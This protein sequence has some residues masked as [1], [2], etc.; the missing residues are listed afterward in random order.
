MGKRWS[1][2]ANYYLGGRGRHFH[3]ARA[4]IGRLLED[5][6]ALG[7]DHALCTG[8]ITQMSTP[9]EFVEAGAALQP[10]LSQRK[11]TIIPGNHDRY[12]PEAEQ[13]RWFEETFADS[14]PQNYPEIRLLAENVS[15]ILIDGS[16]ATGLIDSSGWCGK[17][18]LEQLSSMVTDSSLDGHFVVLAMHY[19]LRRMQG[20]PDRKRH[21]LRDDREL[22]SILALPEARIHLVL[23]GHMHRPYAVPVAGRRVICVGSGTDLAHQGGWHRLTLDRT[24]YSVQLERRIWSETEDRYVA[25]TDKIPNQEILNRTVNLMGLLSS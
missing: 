11:F 17:Q 23:H 13:G 2:A 19:G 21:A 24:D 14:A 20:E 10:M 12:T 5:V 18:Q 3:Q 4:R 9:S 15:L 22:E 8:D 7:Y 16:R 25:W 6:E 1:A